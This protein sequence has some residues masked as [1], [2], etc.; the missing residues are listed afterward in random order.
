MSTSLTRAPLTFFPRSRML[1]H[2]SGLLQIPWQV[3]MAQ[4]LRALGARQIYTD[5]SEETW[6]IPVNRLDEARRIIAKYKVR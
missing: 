2:M 1:A 3:Q 4:E 6:D 5:L